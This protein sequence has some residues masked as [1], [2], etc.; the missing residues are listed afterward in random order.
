MYPWHARDGFR[1]SR[2]PCEAAE[3]P[4]RRAHFR[5]CALANFGPRKRPLQRVGCRRGA[6]ALSPPTA[7]ASARTGT[8]AASHR[9]FLWLIVLWAIVTSYN[10]FKPYHTVFT[11][12]QKSLGRDQEIC[13]WRTTQ[14]ALVWRRIHAPG[15][16]R[17]RGWQADPEGT[18]PAPRLARTLAKC[19][20]S[21]SERRSD[22]GELHRIRHPRLNS[23]FAYP[24]HATPT[25]SFFFAYSKLRSR[26][27]RCCS[28]SASSITAGFFPAT[29]SITIEPING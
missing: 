13:M 14:S 9:E 1:D 7:P 25:F 26:S 18:P 28:F 3:K 12:W 2:Q 23:D 20:N 4:V 29:S 10:L 6:S 8:R 27:M 11:E 21:G 15:L 24:R 5:F 22:L 17:A 16:G 19:R